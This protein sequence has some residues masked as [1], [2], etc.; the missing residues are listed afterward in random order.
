MISTWIRP[1]SRL[2]RRQEKQRSWII[3]IPEHYKIPTFFVTCAEPRVRSTMLFPGA[4]AYQMKFS[5]GKSVPATTGLLNHLPLGKGFRRFWG[6]L[7]DQVGSTWLDHVLPNM[8]WN[9]QG[10]LRQAAQK[11]G[12]AGFE[13]RYL[14]QPKKWDKPGEM[15]SLVVAPKPCELPP[16]DPVQS[17]WTRSRHSQLDLSWVMRHSLPG[18]LM[19][20]RWPEGTKDRVCVDGAPSLGGKTCPAYRL[21]Q[22]NFQ[23]A[24]CRKVPLVWSF[25]SFPGGKRGSPPETCHAPCRA[26]FGRRR[27]GLPSG[28]WW[29]ACKKNAEHVP[30]KP[31]PLAWH[32]RLPWG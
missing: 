13:H 14:V 5:E 22:Q 15:R 21:G 2:H 19:A 23:A 16:S 4:P 30:T 17:W 31:N 18:W 26:F 6:I 10:L 9:R 3:W 25:F 1:N 29:G 24:A 12:A 28:G 8:A 11:G 32:D 7:T 27:H 20:A